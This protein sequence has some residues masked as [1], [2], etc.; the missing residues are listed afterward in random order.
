MKMLVIQLVL[1]HQNVNGKH[2][3]IIDVWVITILL[4]SSYLFGFPKMSTGSTNYFY[5]KKEHIVPVFCLEN[6]NKY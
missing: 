6:V 2:H 3:W 1:W 4:T 5:N